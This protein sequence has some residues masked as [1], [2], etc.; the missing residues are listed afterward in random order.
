[1]QKS[2]QSDYS[3][4]VLPPYSILE[5]MRGLYTS[6]TDIRRRV[7]MYVA[8]MIAEEKPINF[9]ETVPY[10]IIDK[11]TPTY[12]DCVFKERAI[13]RERVRLAL[14]LDLKEFG[15]HG[16]IIEDIQHAFTD[17]KIITTP[18]VNVI[19]IGCERCP[20]DSFFVS[21][22]CR[23]CIAHPCTIVC[24]VKAVSIGETSAII[25][26]AKCIKC[27]R[28]AQVCPY[29]SIIFRERPCQKA[30]GVE[31]IFSDE[32]GFAEINPQKCVSCGLCIIACPF[33]AIAE[34]SEMVQIIYALRSST[35]VFAEVAPSF[36]GQFGPLVTP[37]KLITALIHLGF[38]GVMEVAY[39]A[40]QDVLLETQELLELID[41]KS[42]PNSEN[43][44]KFIGTSCCPAWVDAARKNFPH[45]AVNLSESFTPMVETAKKIKSKNPDAKVVFIGPCVAKKIESFNPKVSA[46]VDYIL[47]FEE[48]AALF[49]AY[50]IDPTKVPEAGDLDDASKLGRSFP[51]AGGV[52]SAITSQAKKIRPDLKESDLPVANADTLADC[53][54]MLKKIDK[55]QVNPAP[56]VVE[57]MACPFGCVGGPG[58]L[59]PLRRAQNEAEKFKKKA[60]RDFPE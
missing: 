8:R 2:N 13:V 10:L 47:T 48:L 16:P 5:K 29:N 26:Q 14:G 49:Q 41:S 34:K 56:L 21:N 55:K 45:L 18:I 31:A 53:L 59:A 58:T 42:N 11:D 17:K 6:V 52:I 1:M 30:C 44:R 36:G 38:A 25:D 28:C 4:P 32:N 46:Y 9:I 15:A 12:R 19:K 20:T 24:P 7:L 27:G 39:G 22:M 37:G 23:K 3:M 43:P 50:N 33:S 35:S 54:I 57:G 51:V 40:D 60:T